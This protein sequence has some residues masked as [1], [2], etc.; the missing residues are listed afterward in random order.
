MNPRTPPD[1]QIPFDR[2]TYREGQLLGSRDLQDDV[3][4]DQRLRA[5]HTRYLHDTWGVALGFT[6]SAFAGSTTVHVGPGYA[7]DSSGRD[8]VLAE[9]LELN[10]PG[11]EAPADLIL[12]VGYRADRQYRALPDV[13]AVCGRGGLDPRNERPVF[14]WRTLETLDFTSDVP[15]ASVRAQQGALLAAADLS[16]RRNAARMVRPH[17]GFGS[18]HVRPQSGESLFGEV[19]IDTSDAGFSR[20]PQY[21]AR[22]NPAQSS[23]SELFIAYVDSLSFIDR[24]TAGS[25]FYNL[26]LASVFESGLTLTWLGV[27]PVAGCEPVPNL[28]LFFTL[29]GFLHTSVFINAAQAIRSE[30]FR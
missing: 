6:I 12:V 11:T 10:L 14:A 27:E 25:F 7:V 29:A 16:V 4:T 20:T 5:L 13:G 21:F 26:P 9:N 8:I 23:T 17:I 30:V 18:V 15:L 19:Q 22:L 28:Q 3:R 2:I 24:P 1:L